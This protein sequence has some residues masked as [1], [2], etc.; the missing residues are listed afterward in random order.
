MNVVSGY[1]SSDSSTAALM[2]CHPVSLAVSMP[3]SRIFES[4]KSW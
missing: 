3:M 2:T 4:A 1:S